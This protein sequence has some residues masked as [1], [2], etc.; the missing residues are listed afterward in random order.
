MLGYDP[1]EDYLHDL[2]KERDRLRTVNA[3]LL[4]ALKTLFAVSTPHIA[5]CGQ[6]PW[7]IA[8]A[9]IEKHGKGE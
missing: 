7:Q 6:S 8:K 1:D 3:E 9:A 2:C 5:E 4:A